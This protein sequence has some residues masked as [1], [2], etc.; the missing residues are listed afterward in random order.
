MFTRSK[1]SAKRSR[2][3]LKSNNVAGV[4]EAS[5]VSSV[6]SE[7]SELFSSNSNDPAMRTRLWNWLDAKFTKQNKYIKE[8]SVLIKT[9]IENNK[10]CL[11]PEFEQKF[12]DLTN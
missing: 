10:I 11:I 5:D 9:L 3:E 7:I 8:Q 4:N 12:S 2:R 1:S 6:S